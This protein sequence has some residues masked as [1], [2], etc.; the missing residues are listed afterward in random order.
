MIGKTMAHLVKYSIGLEPPHTQTTI[1]ERRRLADAV[2]GKK[3]V[4]EIGVYEGSTTSLLAENMA[5]DGKL[6]AI[7]PFLSGRTGICW[8]KHIAYREVKK[9]REGAEVRFVEAYS[10]D[11]ARTIDGAFDF[12]F[13]DGDHSLAGITRDW[14]DWSGRVVIDGI[15][16]LHDTRIPAHNPNVANLG[17]YQYFESHIRHDKRFELIEQV[18]SLSLMR[19][20]G[21]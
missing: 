15:I 16:A 14:A 8:G 11:A 17:S 19:V 20:T 5:R 2:R 13:I 12:I 18:D 1:A 3:S 4:V 21:C 10:H 7:D 9:I 6:F